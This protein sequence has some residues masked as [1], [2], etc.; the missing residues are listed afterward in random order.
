M[1]YYNVLKLC[2]WYD[3]LSSNLL[4]IIVSTTV[5]H[6]IFYDRL[7]KNRPVTDMSRAWSIPRSQHSR[8]G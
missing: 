3:M 5:N 6:S 4:Y 1:F 2:T 7:G 8:K